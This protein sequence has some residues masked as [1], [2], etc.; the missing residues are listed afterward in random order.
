MVLCPYV[1]VITNPFLPPLRLQPTEVAST[2]WVPLRALLSPDNRTSSY[3]D[4]SNRLANQETGVKRWMLRLLLG[5]MEFAAIRLLPSESLHCTASPAENEDATKEQSYALSSV[6]TKTWESLRGQQP[7]PAPQTQPLLLWGLTLGVLADFLDMLPPNNALQLWTYPTFTPW[8]VRFAIWAMTY[9][10]KQQKLLQITNAPAESEE[11]EPSPAVAAV[12][13]GLDAVEPPKRMHGSR[14]LSR[15]R[16]AMDESMVLVEEEKENASDV[17]LPGLGSGRGNVSRRN[18]SSAVGTLLEG[19]YDLLRKAV[20]VALVGRTSVLATLF[21]LLAV[22]AR[23]R[24]G[25]RVVKVG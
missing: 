17:G 13:E 11:K 9:K 21:I 12:E 18:V 10:F 6:A 19:Y 22:R 15:S 1:F 3:E 24:G 4:V 25:Q 2:H 14:Y 7:P 5:K 8:D 16:S 20:G 23:R